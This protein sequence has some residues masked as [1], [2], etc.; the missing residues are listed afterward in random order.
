[1]SMPAQTSAYAYISTIT[2]GVFFPSAAA[3]FGP[4][5]YPVVFNIQKECVQLLHMFL[6]PVDIAAHLLRGSHT[7]EWY[8]S[9]AKYLPSYTAAPT[10]RTPP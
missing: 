8:A 4:L 9:A 1:M 6:Y 3:F 5:V 10:L 2:D 7:V